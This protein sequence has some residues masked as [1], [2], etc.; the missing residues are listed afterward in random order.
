MNGPCP[1]RSSIECLR[2]TFLLYFRDD[3]SSTVLEARKRSTP[4]CAGTVDDA[5]IRKNYHALMHTALHDHRGAHYRVSNHPAYSDLSSS[6]PID[7][8]SPYTTGDLLGYLQGDENVPTFDG[9][10]FAHHTSTTPAVDLV[11]RHPF[12]GHDSI[13][14]DDRSEDYDRTNWGDRSSEQAIGLEVSW[15][16]LSSPVVPALR[17]LD[18]SDYSAGENI[19][20]STDLAIFCTFCVET[21][22]DATAAHIFHN[23]AVGMNPGCIDDSGRVDPGP[24]PSTGLN[25]PSSLLSDTATPSHMP[26]TFECFPYSGEKDTAILP[27]QLVVDRLHEDAVAHRNRTITIVKV[28]LPLHTASGTCH[29]MSRLSAV[30]VLQVRKNR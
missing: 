29:P 7:L 13:K 1:Y 18:L 4:T 3:C 23:S 8:P 11:S 21:T 17:G 22:V 30:G 12:Q 25:L 20:T 10:L 19:R 2:L 15:P 27:Q 14:F 26:H 24:D 28:I 9:L 5:P 6:L 16:A